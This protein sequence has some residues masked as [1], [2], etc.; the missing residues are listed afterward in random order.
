[1]AL[2]VGGLGRVR[3]LL[4]PER[5]A[6]LLPEGAEHLRRAAQLRTCANQQPSPGA[7]VAGVEA[8][9]RCRCGQGSA[10]SRRRCGRGSS[11]SPS[12]DVGRG[13]PSPGVDVGRGEPSLGADVVQSTRGRSRAEHVRMA[14]RCVCARCCA[15]V[16]SPLVQQFPLQCRPRSRASVRHWSATAC[17]GRR[18]RGVAGGA[19]VR[20]GGPLRR[21]ADRVLRAPGVSAEERRRL[22]RRVDL[23]PGQ[24]QPAHALPQ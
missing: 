21:G 7:D 6:T 20:S 9:S 11:L 5:N 12:A 3:R 14:Y 22:L 17:V 24:C 1:M 16:P 15:R 10:Q 8:Q 23:Q 2:Q 4:L 19:A 18:R 13:G